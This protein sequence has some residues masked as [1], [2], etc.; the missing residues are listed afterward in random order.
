VAIYSLHHSAIGK[1][2]QPRV[3]TASAHIRYVARR[4]ACV[5]LMAER[6]PSTSAKAQAWFR[7]QEDDD[8]KNARVCDKVLLALPRELDAIQRA[9][10]VR[11]FA[12][13][14]TQGRASW[15][16]AFHEKGKDKHNPHCHLVIRDRDPETGR[17][18][19]NMSER[20]STDRIRLLWE[21][22]AN[23]ALERAGR[24]ER[25]DRRT[26]ERQGIARRPMVHEGLSARQMTTR[27]KAINSRPR[28]YRNGVGAQSRERLVDYRKVDQNR[29]RPQYNEYLRETEADYW[30]AM[31]TDRIARQWRQEEV[32]HAPRTIELPRQREAPVEH[33]KL[34][35]SERLAR[36]R[37]V[38]AQDPGHRAAERERIMARWRDGREPRQEFAAPIQRAGSRE[39][40]KRSFSEKLANDRAARARDPAYRSREREQA[41]TR[42]RD[43][44]TR[45]LE[46]GK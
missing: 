9:E 1:G 43:E 39:D 15:L 19:C 42:W 32:E 27:G 7:S 8:R 23:S 5:R 36:N 4:R 3:Y 22:Q 21:R 30:A 33:E 10:L 31:D 29:S 2:T 11:V 45:D 17:R 18:V 35:F 44:R 28:L 12:E 14:V 6:M 13:L 40:A 41:L 24:R 16:A 46:H 26:L 34:S 37:A 25:I 38:R 20:G